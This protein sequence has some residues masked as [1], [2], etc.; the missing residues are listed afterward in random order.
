MKILLAAD[1]HFGSVPEGLAQDLAE[2]IEQEAPDVT[3]IAGDLTLAAR[4]A[5]FER[6]GRWLR[7]LPPPVLVIPGN[8][9]MPYWN[10][11]K[12]F[13]YPFHRYKAAAGAETLMPV[14]RQGGGVVLGFNTTVSW[15]PHLRWQEGVA[16]LR[17]ILAAKDFLSS[18][19]ASD[20]KAVAAHHP[21][22]KLP[23]MPRARPV[24]R[25][26]L[27]IRAFAEREFEGQKIVAVGAPT[28]LSTRMRGEANGFWIVEAEGGEIRC[29]LRLRRERRFEEA[30]RKV[31]L[32]S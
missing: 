15:Q 6:A 9:D 5:E 29:S 28:A 16:R 12:R 27:A 25:A 3:V 26:S 30:A 14:V 1:L 2:A 10:L 32:T 17:D 21:F 19:P 8:H 22:L 11:I 7:S 18:V 4:H 23:E 24:R 31:F 20:F 13:A